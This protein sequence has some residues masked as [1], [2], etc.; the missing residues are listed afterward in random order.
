[1]VLIKILF[2]L[3]ADFPFC[4]YSLT[5]PIVYIY[6]GDGSKARILEEETRKM[7]HDGLQRKLL[8]FFKDLLSSSYPQLVAHIHINCLPFILHD[9]QNLELIL[10]LFD[11][12][13]KL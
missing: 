9:L 2:F 10:Y 7:F 6:I 12:L 1:M 4:H 5:L 3:L 13:V 8:S 11:F